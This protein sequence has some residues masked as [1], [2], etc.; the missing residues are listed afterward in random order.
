MRISQYKSHTQILTYV[1]KH[2][3]CTCVPNIGKTNVP[4][5]T[6]KLAWYIP[7]RG[8]KTST[9]YQRYLLSGLIYVHEVYTGTE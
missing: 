9:Y 4:G 5:P 2:T 8:H 6:V 1:Y 3:Y 7:Q